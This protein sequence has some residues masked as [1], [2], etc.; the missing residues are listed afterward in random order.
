MT[1]ASPA[2]LR[3]IV[4][5]YALLMLLCGIGYAK[6]DN[7]Q[8]D[9]DAVAFMDVADAIHAHNWPVVI[10]GYW[11]PAYAATLAIG[12]IVAHPSRWDELQTY[13]WVNFFIFAACI[14][15]TYYFVQGLLR[16]RDRSLADA[17]SSPTFSQPAL[18]LTAL[19]LLFIAFQ[20][21]LPIGAVRA[22][23]LLLFFFFMAAGFLL[24]LQS[25]G[26]FV[27]YPLLGLALGFAY[28]TKSFAFLPSGLLLTALFVYGLTRKNGRRGRIISG[29]LLA[30]VVFIALAGPYILAISKQRGRPTTGESARLNYAFFVDQTGRWHEWRTND[31]GHATASFKH[32]EE[33]LVNVPPVYS[34]AQ[35]PLGTYPLWF[36]PSYWTDTLTPKVYLHG[37]ILRLK[38]TTV[39]LLRY[40]TGH[41]EAFVLFAVL[42]FSG[43]FFSRR[44]ATWLPLIPATLWGL[45][46]LGIYFPIDLQDRYLTP[47]FLFVVLPILAMLRRPKN[48]YQ[49]E[50]ATGVALAFAGLVLATAVTDL[51][52]RRRVESVTG[53]PRGAYSKQIYPA[54]KGIAD[55]G[56]APGS[57]VACFGDVACYVDHYWARI[58]G[59]PIRA[60]IEV[61]DDSDPGAFWKHIT[62][63]QAVLDALR[64]RQ[65]KVIVGSFDPTGEAPE[66]WHQLGSSNFYAYPL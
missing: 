49:A 5:L 60:E 10:N 44:R 54:A 47:A 48:G 11:N 37:H 56:I 38:R 14:G 22:D 36:D 33:L 2:R 25:T 59:T 51:A 27:Y 21:E 7:Y 63:K 43:C 64:A 55:L 32:H 42:L 8:L 4:V 52:E 19:G 30:G 28:L 15:A 13:F 46:M 18:L 35:H 29:V 23:G 53:Y 50:V 31:L 24:R 26:R 65:I 20:R 61:P 62:D 9:G 3:T 40:L 41:L 17:D 6:Y 45:L 39:L 34:Y 66:G 58:A 16:V 12:Q 57:T 1:P